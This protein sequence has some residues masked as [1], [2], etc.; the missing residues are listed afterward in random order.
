[1]SLEQAAGQKPAPPRKTVLSIRG[2][3]IVL[4]LL[5]VV[6]LMLD[7]VR[8]LEASRSERI[9]LAHRE[10]SELARRGVDAQ[11]EIITNVRA[12]LHVVAGADVAA[13]AESDACH[14]QLAGYATNVPWLK[15]LSIVGANGRILCATTAQAVG[16]DVSDRDYFRDAMRS[17][18]FTLSNYLIERVR[19][20]PAIMASYPTTSARDG[21][22]LVILAAVDLGWVGRLA[23]SVGSR[24]G[25]VVLI[26]DATGTML[27]SHPSREGWIGK[28]FSAHPLVRAMLTSAEGTVTVK[29]L[30]DV[31]RIYAF[32]RVPW[33]DAR[34]AVGLNER[35][36]LERVDREI[37]IAYTQ[38]ALFGLL[39]LLL[40][41][42]GGDRLI[43][44]PIRSLTRMAQRFG[45]GDLD[46]RA[47]QGAWAGEFVPLAA[48]LN[49]MA[50]RL[51]A[52]E[53]ELRA[54]NEHLA[55]LASIDSLSGLAN[56]RGFDAQLAA[57]W[58]RAAKGRHP[59][60]L[61]MIDVDH[62]KTFNDNYGHVEGDECLRRIGTA[63]ARIT[64]PT[65]FAAR[66]GGEEFTLL[67]PGAEVETA[68]AIAERLRRAIED[69]GITHTP[70][71][72]GRVTISIGVASLVPGE[73]DSAEMLVE[74]ADAG[75]YAAKRRGRNT[76]VA[77]GLLALAEIN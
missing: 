1:M 45:R 73:A 26:V 21:S 64:R 57:E 63:L 71:P 13:M 61:L 56:R 6:P 67:L 76:V 75:L 41:W 36:V 65:D 34:L 54:A 7:R 49:D 69:L 50:T 27:A 33:T 25:A 32:M 53:R 35:V 28:S 22:R 2:R 39:V 70:A 43:V 47:T 74:A 23:A 9:E 14:G 3:L 59:I 51:A 4:A 30:D 66:Y 62:F 77:H 11:R 37:G 24:D 48:A 72:T 10:A 20:S 19:H 60:A 40:A 58:Q 16:L 52:R 46:A 68:I 17:G 12:L 42:F 44:E 31:R 55:E 38:L 5:A 18:E 8:L 29:G 15:G